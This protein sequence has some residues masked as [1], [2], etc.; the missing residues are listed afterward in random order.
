MKNRLTAVILSTVLISGCISFPVSA[1]ENLAEIAFD[2]ID[3]ADAQELT[4][5]D[6]SSELDFADIEAGEEDTQEETGAESPGEESAVIEDDFS[7]SPEDFS[8]GNANVRGIDDEIGGNITWYYPGGIF[9]TDTTVASEGCVLLGLEGGHYSG[10]GAGIEYYINQYR[11]EAC[12][13]GVPDP[14]DPS[15]KLTMDDYMPVRWSSDMQYIARIRS[16]ET[17]IMTTANSRPNG[18]E[19]LSLKSPNGLESVDELQGWTN[20]EVNV[21]QNICEHWYQG[22]T[23]WVQQNGSTYNAYAKMINPDNYYVGASNF[24]NSAADQQKNDIWRNVMVAEFSRTPN[25]DEDEGY[26][27]QCIQTIE[28]QKKLINYTFIGLSHHRIKPGRTMD[29]TLKFKVGDNSLV[30]IPDVTDTG[31]VTWESDHPEIAAVDEN[32]TI[33]SVA[34]GVTVIRASTA[35]GWKASTTLTVEKNTVNIGGTEIS[36]GNLVYTGSK[37]RPT[38]KIKYTGK[39]FDPAETLKEGRDYTWKYTNAVNAGETITIT[40]NGKGNYSGTVTKKVKVIRKRMDYFKIKGIVKIKTYTG[41]P[42]RQNMTILD[43][44]LNP[45]APSNYTV[46]YVN[47]V[48]PGIVQIRIT[49]KG[50]YTAGTTRYFYITPPKMKKPALKSTKNQITVTYQKA[51]GATGYQISYSLDK[52]TY[53]HIN[54]SSK[55]TKVTLKNLKSKRT[56]YVKVRAYKQ[57]NGECYYGPYS[58]IR[59]IKTK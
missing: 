4:V 11:E 34:P 43:D 27:A 51:V 30:Y 55:T 48:K 19:P 9:P 49:G 6:D 46:K 44:N 31:S 54:T 22:K 40:I 59:S 33:T 18:K 36:I 12:R 1:S 5:E 35:D 52:K 3:E 17:S 28:I 38:L 50:N 10:G 57:V 21:T 16:A 29:A 47:N 23:A 13:E 7:D 42:I 39:D 37:I 56:Y 41:K 25:L 45:V 26:G 24:E 20:S 14:R 53:K 8:S 2:S 15:R 58:D 32:G